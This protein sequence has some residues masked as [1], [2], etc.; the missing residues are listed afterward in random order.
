MQII[1]FFY[2]KTPEELELEERFDE[3]QKLKEELSKISEMD[4]FAN[5]HRKRRVILKKQDEFDALGKGFTVKWCMKLA[6]D[7]V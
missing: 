3:L 2:K 6:F 7:M 1:K 5:Y 4:E